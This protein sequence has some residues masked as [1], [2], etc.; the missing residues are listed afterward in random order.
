[1]KKL[2]C[3]A[4]AAIL[5][6]SAFA[7]D[8]PY[9]KVM[10]ADP[11]SL[12]AQ[13]FLYYKNKNQWIIDRQKGA[14][15]LASVLLDAD[16]HHKDDYNI[17]VQMGRGGE[18][19]SMVVTIYDRDIYDTLLAFADENGENLKTINTGKGERLTYYY[20]GIYFSIERE[21]V[22]VKSTDT[23]TGSNSNQTLSTSSSTTSDYSYDK[24]IYTVVTDVEPWSPAIEKQKAKEA[25]RAEKGMKNDNSAAFL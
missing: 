1:M 9:K 7:Q 4:F 18:K 3:A 16:M 11:Q 19:A 17:C 14:G 24:Y 20:D 21:K 2:L 15:I 10:D 25:R 13:N 8:Y 23:I 12:E 5:A 22:E 6:L